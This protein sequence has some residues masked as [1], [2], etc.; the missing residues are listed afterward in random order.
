MIKHATLG[1]N[2][3]GL[4]RTKQQHGPGQVDNFHF[5]ERLGRPAQ[6][7][8]IPLLHAVNIRSKKVDLVVFRY[9]RY[10]RASEQL[11]AKIVRT[12]QKRLVGL[13][14]MGI[15]YLNRVMLRSGLIENV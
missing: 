8:Q 4:G 9:G 13:V 3:G 1:S 15:Y 11:D 6:I 10:V 7:R 14:F 12:E 2:N 5:S